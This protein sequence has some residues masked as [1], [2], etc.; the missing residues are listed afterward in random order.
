MVHMDKLIDQKY[1][2]KNK[3]IKVEEKNGNSIV[4]LD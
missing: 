2:C 3:T 4:N 1:K